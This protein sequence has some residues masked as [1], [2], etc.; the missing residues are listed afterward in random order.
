[1]YNKAPSRPSPLGK[2]TFTQSWLFEDSLYDTIFFSCKDFDIKKKFDK[3]G[4][5]MVP[6]LWRG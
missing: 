1:M 3:H 5:C 2:A 6:L 4:L